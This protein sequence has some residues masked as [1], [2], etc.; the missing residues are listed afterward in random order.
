[1]SVPEVSRDAFLQGLVLVVRNVRK[2]NEWLLEQNKALRGSNAFLHEQNREMAKYCSSISDLGDA[3]VK[4]NDRV[5]SEHEKGSNVADSL[6]MLWGQLAA[7]GV[8]AEQRQRRNLVLS[9]AGSPSSCTSPSSEDSR[10][11]SPAAPV[12]GTKT[13]EMV[14]GKDY[15][16]TDLWCDPQ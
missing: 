3:V 4:L 1:M 11:V 15:G 14:Y 16:V 6:I 5:D 13:D 2:Q 12:V 9:A 8:V 10:P 7:H